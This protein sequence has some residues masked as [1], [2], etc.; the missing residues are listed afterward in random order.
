M[1]G[2]GRVQYCGR[3]GLVPVSYSKFQGNVRLL[4]GA[5]SAAVMYS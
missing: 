2:E 4:D 5:E 1:P 3:E